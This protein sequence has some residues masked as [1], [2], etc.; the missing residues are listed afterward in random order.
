MSHFMYELKR[1]ASNLLRAKGF[2]LTFIVTIGLTFGALICFFSLNYLLYVKAFPYPNQ[3]RMHAAIGT[4]SDQGHPDVNGVVSYPGLVHLYKKQQVYATAAL[5]GYGDAMVSSMP[6]TPTMEAAYATP[7]YFKLTGTPMALGRAFQSG[8]DLD[9]RIPVA[10]LSHATWQQEFGGKP[11]VL[12]QKITIDGVAFSIIGVT[13]A[14]FAEPQMY[15]QGRLSKLWLPWDFFPERAEIKKDWGSFS[16]RALLVGELKPEFTVAQANQDLSTMMNLRFKEETAGVGF[17]KNHT[18]SIKQQ[19]MPEL[20]Y[21][22]GR[23]SVLLMLAGALAL[24][25]IACVNVVNLLISRAAQRQGVLGIQASVGA[26][27]RHLFI[28]IFVET[29]LLTC[30]ATVFALASAQL[31][32]VLLHRYA[33]K[34][35]PRIDELAI[36][37]V[38]L[39]FAAAFGIVLA[40]AFALIVARTI[41]YRHLI[42][43]LR[44]GGKGVGFQ[45]SRMTRNVLIISQI[46]LATL[47]L[48]GN[49][50][51][52]QAS[53]KEI[54]KPAGLALPGAYHLR[55]DGGSKQFSEPEEKQLAQEI[56][57]RLAALPEVEGAGSALF[58]PLDGRNWTSMLMLEPSGEHRITPNT[59]VVDDV[60]FANSGLALRAGRTFRAD[61][62]SAG[63]RNVVVNASLA[64]ALAGGRDPV[65]MNIFWQGEPEP[66]KVIG[67]VSD[68]NV[69]GNKQKSIIYMSNGPGLNFL[70]KLKPGQQLGAEQVMAMLGNLDRSL[71]VVELKPMEE[72]YLELLSRDI[73][74]AAVALALA[75]LTLFLAAVGIFGVLSYSVRLQRHGIGVRM[76]IGASPRRIVTDV[77]MDYLRPTA[78]SLVL[79]AVLGWACYQVFQRFF[80]SLFV[81]VDILPILVTLVLIV[82]TVVIACLV[83]LRAIVGQQPIMALRND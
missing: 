35:I 60:F 51:L 81:A 61:D 58:S 71:R 59:N 32:I 2:A 79:A 56:K 73:A 24:M 52:L 29:G 72:R 18:V 76:A 30:L 54:T 53:V 11:D 39:L 33:Q 5:V 66:Y 77:L 27:K 16:G 78:I 8:E 17:L 62:V 37:G 48:A 34:Q 3:D 31:G 44:G 15:Y 4:V 10:V 22:D 55:I 7:G 25:L 36:D 9:S 6:G 38:S 83:P 49:A 21:G 68:V 47:L 14:S 75:L 13:A 67:V 69:P 1:S 23:T 65:G 45:I 70:V 20:I 82:S 80:A 42:A 63:A 19:S 46:T 41:N 43:T 64:A 57:R 28:G 40:A 74:S 12:G 26:T 50:E